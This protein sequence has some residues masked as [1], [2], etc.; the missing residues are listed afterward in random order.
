MKKTA[1]VNVERVVKA[2]PYYVFAG[3]EPYD[4]RPDP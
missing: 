2:D 4:F 3:L 1:H